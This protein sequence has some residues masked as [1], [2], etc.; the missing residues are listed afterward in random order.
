MSIGSFKLPGNHVKEQPTDIPYSGKLLWWKIK[1]RGE[2]F[3]GCSLVHA[4]RVHAPWVWSL[5]AHV[6]IEN[7]LVKMMSSYTVETV[8]RG[9]H[10]YKEVWD[11]AIGQVLPCQQECGS[12]VLVHSTLPFLLAKAS[13]LD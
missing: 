5:I 12:E 9:Y 4:P 13:F 1:F 7:E 11:A 6:L 8:V 10:M 2:N 3:H